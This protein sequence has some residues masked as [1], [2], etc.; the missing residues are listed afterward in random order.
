MTHRCNDPNDKLSRSNETNAASGSQ[1]PQPGA[2]RL[3]HRRGARRH[4]LPAERRA[5]VD[6][7]LGLRDGRPPSA[8]RSSWR[9]LLGVV[10]DRLFV[11]L[12]ASP[13]EEA[14]RSRTTDMHTVAR[15]T[16]R[17]RAGGPRPR[18]HR[19]AAARLS[20]ATG[21]HGRCYVPLAD[22]LADRFH[23][24]AFDYRGH[25]DTPLPAGDTIDWE[26]YGDDA[27]AMAHVAAS[28]QPVRPIDGV[29]PLDGRRVPAD[30]GAPRPR[31]CSAARAVRADRVPA[32]RHRRD[33][34]PT[35]SESPLVGRCPPPARH[36]P[37]A[38]RRPSP[39]TPPSRR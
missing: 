37:V 8:G 1:R 34:A 11:I 20:H 19:A 12:V 15:A 21:F 9:S 26:R 30:G 33:A 18:R 22:A 32:R 10:L 16:R 17:R 36:V 29:R 3:R 2:H 13:Q 7:L 31:R 27:E 23:S 24:V 14:S 38:T 28:T 5:A 4:L 35:P 39:T 25:G 6:R